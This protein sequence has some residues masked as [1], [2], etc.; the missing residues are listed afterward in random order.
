MPRSPG[1]PTRS[2]VEIRLFPVSNCC[3][4]DLPFFPKGPVRFLF[5]TKELLMALPRKI[6]TFILRMT[7][8][9]WEIQSLKE[10]LKWLKEK[11]PLLLE[12]VGKEES[13]RELSHLYH[14]YETLSGFMKVAF[15]KAFHTNLPIEPVPFQA[16][17]PCG[18]SWQTT[19]SSWAESRRHLEGKVICYKCREQKEKDDDEQWQ[20]WEVKIDRER[21]LLK[22]MPYAQYLKTD[23]WQSV[24]KNALR[25]ARYRCQLCNKQAPLYVHHRTYERRGE[26]LLSDVIALCQLCHEKHHD[27]HTGE[28]V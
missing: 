21:E 26:E 19:V 10:D 6:D 23:H 16:V 1:H 12:K 20:E 3:R 18:Y 9:H 2:I 24:R 28:D 8:L 13:E 15:K 4:T 27:I 25:H 22:T 7:Q 14:N 17:C 5:P 11:F